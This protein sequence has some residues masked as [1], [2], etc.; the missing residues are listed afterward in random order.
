MKTKKGAIS[1]EMIVYTAIA[2]FVLVLV[3]G[4]ATGAFQKL[5]PWF[6][7]E[8]DYPSEE[9]ISSGCEE[10]CFDEGELFFYSDTPSEYKCECYETY[11]K[12]SKLKKEYKYE[13]CK[14][15]CSSVNMGMQSW[16]F[17]GDG[18]FEEYDC[19]CMSDLI[20]V[21]YEK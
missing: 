3:I 13:E 4:F 9:I 8:I 16:G 11:A 7:P 15:V 20:E 2:V 21:F 19:E 5:V 10:L 12:F 18:L 17:N 1:V 14:A 6:T